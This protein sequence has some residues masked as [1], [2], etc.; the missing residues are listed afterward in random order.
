MFFIIVPIIIGIVNSIKTIYI[1]WCVCVSR[2]RVKI[3]LFEIVFKWIIKKRF[4]LGKEW[5]LNLWWSG[6]KSPEALILLAF[7][8]QKNTV[9]AAIALSAKTVLSVRLQGFEPWTP[10][11]RV[12]CST[13]WAKGASRILLSCYFLNARCIIYQVCTK[14]Q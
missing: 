11:L 3:E 5:D 12:R 2:R 7:R 8:V 1:E 14:S 4:A 6:L 9:P 10:W 13:N